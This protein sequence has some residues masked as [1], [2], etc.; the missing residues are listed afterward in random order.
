MSCELNTTNCIVSCIM[1]H[2]I[3]HGRIGACT[4]CNEWSVCYIASSQQWAAWISCWIKVLARINRKSVQQSGVDKLIWC[5]MQHLWIWARTHGLHRI[6]LQNSR[7][8]IWCQ[9]DP[10]PWAAVRA[11]CINWIWTAAKTW[12][13]FCKDFMTYTA[14]I[15]SHVYAVWRKILL[16]CSKAILE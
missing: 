1:H 6:I 11:I 12:H 3:I 15:T 4:I 8:M 10:R 14:A 13:Y 5:F 7:Q 16:S 9:T 2:K